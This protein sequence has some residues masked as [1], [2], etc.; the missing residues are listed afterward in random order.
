[1]HHQKEGIMQRRG[2]SVD[3]VATRYT[4]EYP[5]M[6]AFKPVMFTNTCLIGKARPEKTTQSGIILPD[7]AVE[8]DT[9]V[10]QTGKLLAVGPLFYNR[11]EL[12][13]IPE[14]ARP[15]I[16]DIVFFKHY[17]G[18]RFGFPRMDENGKIAIDPSTGAPYPEDLYLLMLDGQITMA[19]AE[20]SM[21]PH[22]RFFA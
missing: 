13:G 22:V 17:S 9:F 1:M 4:N 16:G 11:P 3:P 5:N 20:E 2:L 10:A 15:K 8:R 6:P 18:Y 7:D 12:E 14:E 21:V 19:A